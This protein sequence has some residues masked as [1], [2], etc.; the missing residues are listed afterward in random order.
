MSGVGFVEGR[1]S[2]ERRLPEWFK[3]RFPGGENY[4]RLKGLMRQRGLHTI[5]EEAHCP[6]MGECWEAGTATFLILGD[7][8][9]RHCAYCA[10]KSGRPQGVDQLEP[11]RLALAVK[12]L[13]LKYA[14][15]T[16]VDRDD[17]PD[18]GAAL[19]AECIRQVRAEMPD[20][21]VEVLTPD[22]Q[23]DQAAID[24]VIRAR[25]DVFNHNIETVPRLYPRVRF[26]AKYQ[27]SLDLVRRVKESDTAIVTKSGLM[28]GL[29]ETKGEL[30]ET[31]AD[32][33]RHGCDI[34][35]VGQYLRPSPRHVAVDRFYHPDEFR[36]LKALG[37]ALG[38]R[39][40]EA[41]PLV[42]SSYHAHEQLKVA[43][44]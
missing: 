23:G 42:R 38:F 30:L 10:V 17:L 43:T 27:Q 33:V 41:G 25:P 22:F 28:V 14:V 2:P 12:A 39:H 16:S 8:C 4:N 34:L 21:R 5:C 44:T 26:K 29:G 20:C 13:G 40:V 24:A 18:G 32:L 15:I 11:R 1:P 6:N 3:V 19:F 36:E 35:T 37:E 9:T 7:I 31:M